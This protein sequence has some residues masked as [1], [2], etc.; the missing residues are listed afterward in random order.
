MGLT[1]STNSIVGLRRT[2]LQNSVSSFVQPGST[3]G[4]I[5]EFDLNEND[6]DLLSDPNAVSDQKQ[7]KVNTRPPPPQCTKS[8]DEGSENGVVE[9]K[10]QLQLLKDQRK[11]ERMN[12]RRSMS[13]DSSSQN[14]SKSQQTSTIRQGSSPAMFRVEPIKDENSWP[15]R[16]SLKGY[17]DIAEKLDGPL[18]LIQKLAD[19]QKDQVKSV[20]FHKR[21][22]RDKSGSSASSSRQIVAARR[23]SQANAAEIIPIGNKSPL[24]VH[25]V[26]SF[27]SSGVR[28]KLSKLSIDAHPTLNDPIPNGVDGFDQEI[29]ATQQVSDSPSGSAS[30]LAS[31][32]ERPVTFGLYPRKSTTKSTFQQPNDSI[33]SSHSFRE[34]GKTISATSS[35]NNKRPKE[36][37]SLLKSVLGASIGLDCPRISVREIASLSEH[38]AV[39]ND[40]VVMTPPPSASNGERQNEIDDA[41]Q[42]EELLDVTEGQGLGKKT[43]SQMIRDKANYDYN[44]YLL[45]QQR[46][47]SINFIHKIES[48]DIV[49]QP[50]SLKIKYL[51]LHLLG[52]KIGKG[53]FG[54]VKEGI[55]TE[56]LQRIAVKV[57]SKKRVKKM[58][59]GVIREIKLLRRLKHK[60]IVTL[61]DVFAKVEDD[62]G[63][64]GIFPWFL[65]IEEEPIVWLFEN[66]EEEE[67]M[68]KILKWYIVMEFCPCSL[69]TILDHAPNH[70]IPISDA[71][72]FGFIVFQTDFS[73]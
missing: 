48:N 12:R 42:N 32:Q 28:S 56:S 44:E 66:G 43:L 58:V 60:N 10:N 59:D 4:V 30:I 5:P 33:P 68:V 65:T 41:L 46:H 40:D 39:A 57:I 23:A 67:K 49:Y 11:K 14:D 72:R 2:S 51:G 6:E 19:L 18:I 26:N 52:E 36:K 71:H 16:K 62:E 13:T 64:I 69:Q 55:C 15:R 37:E 24:S 61:I 50:Q 17:K 63:K 38:K 27:R 31:D 29:S 54:K 22:V 25:S 9:A 47:D 8:V 35:F 20:E 73:V 70:K 34:G 3:Q 45:L 21:H 53:A 1:G 7:A